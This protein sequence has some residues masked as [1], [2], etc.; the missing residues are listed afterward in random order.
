MDKT[1]KCVEAYRR[2][3]NL[4]LVGAELGIPWQTVY[5][6]LRKAGEPVMGDK[7]QY[8]SE[9]DRLAAAAESEFQRLVPDAINRN[10]AEFQSKVDFEVNGLTIDIKASTFRGDRWAFSLKKQERIA[11]FFACFAYGGEAYRL[12][13]IPG[14][15]C[16]HYQTISLTPHGKWWDYE[17]QPTM[18]AAFFLNFK[19]AA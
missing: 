15:I 12:L 16:R 3:K 13:L 1:Q 8:G 10:A 11:D 18:L 19:E 2:L 5:V 17:V 6:H 7:Q 4:K 14:E 9:R